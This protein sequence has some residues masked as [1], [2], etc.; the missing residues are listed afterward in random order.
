MLL[1]LECAVAIIQSYVFIVLS[2]LYSS[3]ST[4]H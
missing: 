3:E 1:V 2:T 4:S